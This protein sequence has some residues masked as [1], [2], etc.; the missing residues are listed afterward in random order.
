MKY[1]HSI[2]CALS[3]CLIAAQAYATADENLN[4]C[5]KP[6]FSEFQPSPNKYNQS[7]NEFSLVASPNTLANSISVEVALGTG[8]LH[9]G[10]KDLV[11]MPRSNGYLEIKGRLNRPI[12]H[13]FA[14]I[15][16]TAKSSE[17]CAKSDGFFV[18][19]H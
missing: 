5:D 15:T 1:R 16:V 2:G 13:G 4:N 17:G 8:R 7:F 10:Q 9:F 18:R 12:E 14:K 11:I 3:M 6:I 19:V